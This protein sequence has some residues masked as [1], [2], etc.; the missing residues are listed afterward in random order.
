M[1]PSLSSGRSAFWHICFTLPGVS[2][3]SR[4]GEVDH[5]D[6]E[7]QAGDLQPPSL[8]DRLANDAA[9]LDRDRIDRRQLEQREATD[10]LPAAPALSDL[11]LPFV[12]PS[13]LTRQVITRPERAGASDGG[14]F[15]LYGA[16]ERRRLGRGSV[17]PASGASSAFLEVVARHAA[18]I[19]VVVVDAAVVKRS[20]RALSKTKSSGVKRAEGP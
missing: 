15:P 14:L 16:A 6:G 20:L 17:F 1:V 4:V 12:V 9:L 5:R 3:P 7:L 13:W 11:P 19:A 2:L 18:G 8:I 10:A